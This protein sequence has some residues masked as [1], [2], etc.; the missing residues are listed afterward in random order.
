MRRNRLIILAVAIAFGLVA[1]FMSLTQHS[2]APTERIVER[3]TI[4]TVDVL[5]AQTDIAP[6][7]AITADK[8]G[9]KQWPIAAA[10]GFITRNEC[11]SAPNELAGSFARAPLISGEP[12]RP[13]K[14]L[15]KDSRFM[16][17]LLG[18]GKRAIAIPLDQAGGTTAGGGTAAAAAAARRR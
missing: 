17:V 16:S 9:W 5:T 8:M 14:L 12:L 11:P 1:A 18:P 10:A 4:D 13:E 3:V 2:T 15:T 6:G 7:E